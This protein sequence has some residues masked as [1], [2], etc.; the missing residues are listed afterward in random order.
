MANEKNKK[1]SITIISFDESLCIVFDDFVK[2]HEIGDVMANSLHDFFTLNDLT[3]GRFNSSFISLKALVPFFRTN[4]LY[5]SAVF[6]ISWLS[7]M[8]DFQF[9]EELDFD[10]F[11]SFI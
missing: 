3:L 8:F 9:M 2:I 4:S 5:L 10:R 7:I 6:S 11:I 1:V